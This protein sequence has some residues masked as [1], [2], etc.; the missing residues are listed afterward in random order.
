MKISHEDISKHIHDYYDQSVIECTELSG[1]YENTNFKV[2]LH[3]T[4]NADNTDN[5]YLFKIY[6]KKSME[7]VQH[8]ISHTN[9]VNKSIS[10]Q[11]PI[12]LL[13]GTDATT[14]YVAKFEYSKPAVLF[15][16]IQGR[17]PDE[18]SVSMMTSI[19]TQL[20]KLHSMPLCDGGDPYGMGHMSMI[21]YFSTVESDMGLLHERM[22]HEL[23]SFMVP[24]ADVSLPET[25]IHGDLFLD[26]I[27]V[28]PDN[29][30][31]TII[32]FEEIAKAP[33]VLDIAMTMIGCIPDPLEPNMCHTLHDAYM[34]FLHAYNTVRP[35][36]DSEKKHLPQ[37][38][39]FAMLCMVFWRYRNGGSNRERY[40]IMLDNLDRFDSSCEFYT[41]MHGSPPT[42]DDL[43][44]IFYMSYI[45]K[46]YP[47]P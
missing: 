46:F 16:F 4:D 39:R 24:L 33:A 43:I 36:S 35:L 23:V 45:M 12:P 1:G 22:Y 14:T 5:T 32:D 2:V 42:Y 44:D 41:I 6:N 28:S 15:T 25:L 29:G 13:C 37:Y 19:G 40:K 11:Q 17:C 18:P 34:E 30:K 31:V 47:T 10:S 9:Y 21:S 38:I 7:K 26:N 27:V 8:I 20:A 3:N